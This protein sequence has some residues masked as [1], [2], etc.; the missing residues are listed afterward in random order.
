LR[1]E[2]FIVKVMHVYINKDQVNSFILFILIAKYVGLRSP[3]FAKEII[4]N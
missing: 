3:V 1:K 2:K 4:N